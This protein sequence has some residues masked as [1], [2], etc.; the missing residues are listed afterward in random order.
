MEEKTLLK[1]ALVCSIFGILIVFI[2]ADKLEPPLVNISDI[3]K[4]YIDRDVKIH[5]NIISSKVTSSVIILD[6][7]D[8]TGIIKVVAFDKEEFEADKNQE[9]EIFGSVKDYN[10]VLE[11][12]SKKIIF[13]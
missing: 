4:S 2:F 13:L 6:V 3:S 1:I 7:K 11:I 5:G 10:G 9:A 8:D 12:E